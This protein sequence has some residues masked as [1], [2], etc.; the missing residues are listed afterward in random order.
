M[1]EYVEKTGD[2]SICHELV[3]YIRSKPLEEDEH[4]RYESPDISPISESVINHCKRALDMVLKR[5]TGVHGLLLFGSGDWNDGMD[6]VGAEGRGE[7]VWLTWFFSHTARR[8]GNLLK[9]PG[10]EAA[11]GAEKY[12]S[13]AASFGRT[14]NDAWDG[15]W[16]LRGYYD[17]G[18][19]LGS[20][21]SDCCRI[22]S[23]AQSFSVY[24]PESDPKRRAIALNSAVQYL[25][26]RKNKFVQLFD[27]PFENSRQNPGYIQSYGPGFRENGGQY[28]HAAIWLV[29]ALLREGRV[30][31]GYMMLK[32][33]LPAN[34]DL[35]VYEAEPYVIAAT[36]TPTRIIWAGPDGVGIPALRMAVP[37]CV[38]DFWA[39]LAAAGCISS[40]D[41]PEL[42]R[43]HRCLAELRRYGAQD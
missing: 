32:T 19:P 15:Q 29:Q 36:P 22:D 34:H 42:G 21:N 1:C 27:P 39:A 7:S 5:G 18:D 24:C 8:F 25:F 13:A 2:T 23:I 9:S 10:G 26:D 17:D 12:I 14:A 40:P 16:Y 3:P 4:D 41:S 20:Q 30:Q 37:V 31:D 28:T 11:S 33:L 35:A 6:E 43:L 38:E